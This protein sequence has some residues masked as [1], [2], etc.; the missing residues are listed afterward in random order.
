MKKGLLL[1]MSLVL[2]TMTSCLKEGEQT[3]SGEQQMFYVAKTTDGLKYAYN[4]KI[5]ITSTQI[6]NAEADKWYVISWMWNSSM[7]FEGQG[8]YKTTTS[9]LTP[10]A[11][12]MFYA[13]AVPTNEPITLLKGFQPFQ[14]ME[15]TKT[16]GDYLLYNVSY[17]KKEGEAISLKLYSDLKADTTNP[18]VFP[19]HVRLYKTGT[20]LGDAKMITETIA[21]KMSAI[22]NLVSFTD[23]QNMEG[24]TLKYYFYTNATTPETKDINQTILKN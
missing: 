11:T 12:G 22:R 4:S 2:L 1:M 5:A 6:S 17:E 21:V 23:N 9:A 18:N 19:F 14:Q 3:M 7:G 13:T 20:G 24:V 10:L 15:L 16:M 8:I